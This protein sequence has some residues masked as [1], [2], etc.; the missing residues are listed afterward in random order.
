MKL[1]IIG[2]GDCGCRLAGEFSRLNKRAKAER[3]V[4]I[5]TRAYAV[6]DDQAILK[7]LTKSSS[8]GLQ[9]VLVPNSLGDES[10][11][12]EAGAE[13]MR[14]ESER[15]MAAMKPGEFFE[16]DAFLI[17]AGAAGSFGSGGA[18][19]I[20]QRLKEH[21]V[22]K[23]VY[24][25]IILP[26]KS[27]ETTPQC[28]YNTAICLKSIHG[29][30][31]AVF[32]VANEGLMTEGNIASNEN[33]G[34]VN[35]EIAL[36]FYDLLC[37]SELG[38]SGNVGARILG[39]GDIAQTLAG[40]TAIGVGKTQFQTSRFPWRRGQDFREKGSGTLKT[41]EAMNAA[42]SRLL[43]S[44]KLEDAGKALYFL[45]VPAKEANVDMSKVLGNHLRELAYNAE[46]RGGDFYGARDF[47]QVTVVISELTYV[48]EV[49]GY[50]DRAAELAQTLKTKK[51]K[52]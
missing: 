8:G 28:V 14:G 42:L 30:A 38:G 32:L 23:P 26:F 44:C 29:I 18:P 34:S 13:L 33:M 24:V 11:S 25:L 51:K 41:M 10:N 48:D 2:I 43:I 20:A 21:Y 16:T 7:V 5:V 9:P 1:L 6:N 3:R 12:I 19:V 15:V 35:K 49:K 17:I 36:P 37:A 50:Y 31:D 52:G 27:E 47:A 40:W 46:I 4:S 45:S 22:G 39:V